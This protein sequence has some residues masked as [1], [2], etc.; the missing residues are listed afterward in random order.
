MS[1]L[2]RVAQLVE[3]PAVNRRVGGSSPS[4]GVAFLDKSKEISNTVLSEA[5]VVLPER[6]KSEEQFRLLVESVQDYAIF[7]LDVNGLVSTW[8]AGAQRIKGYR[9]E[10]II[11][12]HFSRFYTQEDVRAGKTERE[13]E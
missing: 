8:N 4:S 12:Q 9:A 5:R 2:S 7:M 1:V 11:R 6:R 3:Q 13:L 10:E